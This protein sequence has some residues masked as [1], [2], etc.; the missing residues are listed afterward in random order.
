[1]PL[2]AEQKSMVR[3]WFK[4]HRDVAYKKGFTSE[5]SVYFDHNTYSDISDCGDDNSV[6]LDVMINDYI[7]RLKGGDHA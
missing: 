2:N 1:M 7:A 5:L 4:S 6:M 3:K